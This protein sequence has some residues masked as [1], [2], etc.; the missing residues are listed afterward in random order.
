MISSY[1][2]WQPLEEV[3]V[4]RAYPPEYF[5]FI[6]KNSSTIKYIEVMKSLIQ[7]KRNN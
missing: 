1:T 3:I 5:D 4:G 2:C 7:Q 6:E